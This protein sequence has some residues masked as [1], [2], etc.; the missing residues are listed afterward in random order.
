MDKEEYIRDHMQ[1]QKV[2]PCQPATADEQ[3]TEAYFA[4]LQ[5]TILQRA[6]PAR[7]RKGRHIWPG[8]LKYRSSSVDR[9]YK[10]NAH[11]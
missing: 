4:L 10:N 6:S 3:H 9:W 2:G 5:S 1:P 7:D 11:C 8:S